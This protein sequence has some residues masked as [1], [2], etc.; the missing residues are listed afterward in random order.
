MTTMKNRLN[1][2]NLNSPL[3]LGVLT[4]QPSFHEDLDKK[5]VAQLL[6][7]INDEDKK[8]ALAVEK[9]IPKIEKLV[10]K[11]V[12]QMKLGGRL[13]YIGAGTSGRLG[14]LDA[15]EIPPTYGMPQGLVV[16]I[17]AGGE[18][19]L[20]VS[21]ENAE[22]DMKQG[23]ID[24]IGFNITDKDVVVGIATSGTTPYVVAALEN[25][26]EN[27]I[28]TACITCNPDSILS[29]IADVSIELLVGPEYV[30]GSTRMKSG[31]ATKLALNMISTATMIQLGRVKGNSMVNMQLNNAKLVKRAIRMIQN[32]LEVDENRARN[33]LSIHGSVSKVLT[34]FGK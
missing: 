25:C 3:G 21:V 20:R 34:E 2:S 18:K 26:R 13:F 28:F 6:T 5:S 1:E 19:A 23:W 15:S 11:I 4:E 10:V 12:A 31:T 32:S 33:L 7:G 29:K 22:D 14:V 27:G 17:I 30:T 24:L 16:G 9:S 8:V